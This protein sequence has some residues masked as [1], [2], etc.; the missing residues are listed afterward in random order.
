MAGVA[1]VNQGVVTLAVMQNKKLMVQRRHGIKRRSVA[2]KPTE[3]LLRDVPVDTL[4]SSLQC[5]HNPRVVLALPIV[6]GDMERINGPKLELLANLPCRHIF[7]E[8]AHLVIAE[9]ICTWVQRSDPLQ[10]LQ[11]GVVA[12]RFELLLHCKHPATT[13]ISD[14][15]PSVCERFNLAAFPRSPRHFLWQSFA[16]TNLL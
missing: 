16:C 4:Q 8:L 6:P 13:R 14:H 11:D 10:S 15:I 1:A 12:F 5:L 2:S 9:C 3:C 7:L